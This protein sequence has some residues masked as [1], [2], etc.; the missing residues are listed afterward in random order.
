MSSRVEALAGALAPGAALERGDGEAAIAEDGL[1]LDR[2]LG[3][4]RPATAARVWTNRQCL[5]TARRFA[6][7]AGFDAAA[8]ESGTRGWPVF[9]RDSGGTAVVHR[10]G[11]LNF[12]VY[13]VR[14]AG[15]F[16]VTARFE[17]FTRHL[18]YALAAIGVAA[19]TGRVD[20]SYCDGRF[21]IVSG[22]RKVAGTACLVRQRHG[23][24]GLLAHAAIC[25]EGD[26]R[27]DIEAITAFERALGLQPAYALG[28]H[29][30]LA[31]IMRALDA[32]SR[33]Q[34]DN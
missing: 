11:M 5:V 16:D 31:C 19:R 23:Q 8:A 30:S 34:A 21:N 14:R 6:R 22:A 18:I 9:V 32:G 28:A 10:P 33:D 13:E 2:L 26:P 17:A 1:R 24:T 3:E 20:G 27:A 12:S 15:A 29:T 7:M 25:V 4:G